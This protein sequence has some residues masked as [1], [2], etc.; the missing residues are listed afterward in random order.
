MIYRCLLTIECFVSVDV[1]SDWRHRKWHKLLLRL[2]GTEEQLKPC[3]NGATLWHATCSTVWTPC[4]TM[5]HEV[6]F[7]SN[8]QCNIMQHFYW[9]RGQWT[10]LQHVASVWT[11]LSNNVALAHA[12]SLLDRMA[13]MEMRPC[14][15]NRNL[16]RTGLFMC[17]CTSRWNSWPVWTGHYEWH[18]WKDYK[19]RWPR[20]VTSYTFH[21]LVW[22]P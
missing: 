11:A 20:N 6:W 4:C 18:R 1:D 13:S 22:L 5:L 21:P 19:P 10:V 14:H 15:T 3:S 17:C 8:F 12:H 9:S 2:E 16:R 7:G